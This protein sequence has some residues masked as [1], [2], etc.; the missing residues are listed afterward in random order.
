MEG[1]Q[2]PTLV[3]TVYDRNEA[4]M[5]PTADDSGAMLRRMAIIAAAAL[6]TIVLIRVIIGDRP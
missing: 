4:Q 5:G 2:N 1:Y 6:G 3:D